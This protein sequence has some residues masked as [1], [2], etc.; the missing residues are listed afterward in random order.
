MAHET[1]LKEEIKILVW[2]EEVGF[3]SSSYRHSQGRHQQLGSLACIIYQT[4]L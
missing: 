3:M 4:M 1:I 2:T